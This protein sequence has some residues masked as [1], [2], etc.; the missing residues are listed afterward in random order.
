MKQFDRSSVEI[1]LGPPGTGKTTRLL[2]IV[3]EALSAGVPPDRIGYVSFTRKAAEEAVSRACEKF[4]R[5]RGDFPYFRTLHSLCYRY[6]GLKSSD[7]LTGGQL[8][9]FAD[10][11]GVRVTGRYSE[12]GTL[13]GYDVGDRILF[14]ENLSRVQRVPLRKLYDA[15]TDGMSWSQVARV[16]KALREFKEDRGLMDYTDMLLEFV[17]AGN[18]PRLHTLLVDEVQDQSAAQWDVVWLLAQGCERV[19]VAGDDDQGIYRWAGAD[20]DYLVNL[21]GRATVLDQSYR[22]PIDIQKLSGEIIG[23]VR[24]RREKKWFPRDARG[25]ID[26]FQGFS[27]VDVDGDDILV[28]AR[29]E[30][31]LRE[32]VEPELRRAGVVYERHGHPSIKMSLLGSITAWEK[33]RGGKSITGSEARSCYEFMTS[34]EGVRRGFKKLPDVEDD[35][36][37]NMQYLREAGGLLV[38]TVWHEALD[39]LPVSDMTYILSARK[40]GEKLR[41]RPRVKVSTIHGAKGG[42]AK[43]VVLLTEIAQRTHREMREN[44][45]DEARVWYVAVTRASERLSVVNAT[46]SRRCPWL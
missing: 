25:K 21:S 34:G 30:Y 9:E 27:D 18:R 3:D 19:V 46:T 43:H 14:M 20:V 42:E 41:Q 45:Q 39:R 40:R 17:K 28:L 10:Y 29:N 7:V 11:A 31:V 1:V 37:V 13:S 44:P 23:N 36:M 16:A 26:R 8:Q 35:T 22:V 15:D 33:L 2:R 5:D 12:D 24:N 4:S 38:D 32:Q 6:L